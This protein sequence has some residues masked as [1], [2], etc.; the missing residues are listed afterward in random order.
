MILPALCTGL[1]F[2]TVSILQASGFE[3]TGPDNL[4][5]IDIKM[6]G[7]LDRAEG[8]SHEDCKSGAFSFD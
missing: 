4:V 7:T 8:S 3:A 6:S 2:L 1:I 5:K